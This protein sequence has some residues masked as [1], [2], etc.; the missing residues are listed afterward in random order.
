MKHLSVVISLAALAVAIYGIFERR[1]AAR[2]A[3]RVR[4]TELL[5]VIEQLNVD[6]G[7]YADDH[8]ASATAPDAVAALPYAYA[9]KRALLTY[10]ALDLVE[11][12][13]ARS[14]R[15]LTAP[16]HVSLAVSL[17]ACGDLAA[18]RQQW[19]RA[20][21]AAASAPCPV[22]AASHRGLA[23]VLFH[24]GDI[25]GGRRQ[26]Q[27]AVAARTGT[28]DVDR[29][30]RFCTYLAWLAYELPL[31]HGRPELPDRGAHEVAM[32]PVPDPI[33]L[34]TLRDRAKTTVFAGGQYRTVTM[35]D[36]LARSLDDIVS[37]AH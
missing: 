31:E 20:I 16:E 6:E 35:D 22:R 5:G 28:S 8:G 4:L 36:L 23:D 1:Y 27:A 19:E 17:R 34:A 37:S 10:Q 21:V 30:D 12:Q 2:A 7:R 29:Y 3:V 24:L 9:G 33:M 13:L 32:G 18:S 25:D 14:V 11:T 15:M 26:F